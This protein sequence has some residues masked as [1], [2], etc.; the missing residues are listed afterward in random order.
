MNLKLF[1]LFIVIGASLSSCDKSSLN[2]SI[3]G[4]IFEKYTG[5]YT[6]NGTSTRYRVGVDTTTAVDTFKTVI[7]KFVAPPAPPVTDSTL[8]ESK[9]TIENVLG[10]GTTVFATATYE[11]VYPNT[12]SLSN[13]RSVRMVS[14][15]DKVINYSYY[16]VNG[17]RDTTR[18]SGK[19]TKI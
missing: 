5:T 2:E 4:E 12:A 3:S 1:I 14:E 8:N 17:F 18:V 10:T 11:N 9:L 6:A 19:L 16:K 13:F 15:S 7:T